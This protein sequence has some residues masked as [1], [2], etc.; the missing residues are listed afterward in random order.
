MKRS[1]GYGYVFGLGKSSIL[2]RLSVSFSIN[3]NNICGNLPLL[4]MIFAFADFG[5]NR[6]IACCFHAKMCADSG[7][8][9]A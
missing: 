4:K 8:I 5:K 3:A 9:N 7:I 6:G 1:A 2:E